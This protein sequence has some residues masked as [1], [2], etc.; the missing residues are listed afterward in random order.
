M[1]TSMQLVCTI[2]V[3][4]ERSS[5]ALGMVRVPRGVPNALFRAETSVRLLLAGDLHGFRHWW[6]PA[7]SLMLTLTSPLSI[8]DFSW[9]NGAFG[10]LITGQLAPHS[11]FAINSVSGNS[12]GPLATA[13]VGT[14]TQTILLPTLLRL[15]YAETNSRLQGHWMK[16]KTHA[17]H[18]CPARSFRR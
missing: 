13:P 6:C 16:Q 8:F 11:A 7:R 2:T 1:C 9:R 4:G 15:I 3:V 14:P 12:N 10:S 17:T 18:C 5:G